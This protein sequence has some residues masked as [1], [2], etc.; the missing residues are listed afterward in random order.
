MAVSCTETSS[1]QT[2]FGLIS[3]YWKDKLTE[4]ETGASSE[5]RHR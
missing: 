1:S 5:E 2:V 3:P 4:V